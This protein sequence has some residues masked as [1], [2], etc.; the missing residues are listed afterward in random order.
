TESRTE[1]QVVILVVDEEGVIEQVAAV[2]S[3]PVHEEARRYERVNGAGIHR[4]VEYRSVSVLQA[5]HAEEVAA[6]AVV[7]DYRWRLAVGHAWHGDHRVVVAVQ[8]GSQARGTAGVEENVVVHEEHA[9]ERSL[10]ESNVS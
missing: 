3:V 9:A 8:F 5:H 7:L 6:G 1:A 4:C 2:P 10:L